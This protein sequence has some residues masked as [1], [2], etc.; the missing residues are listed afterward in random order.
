ML[1]EPQWRTRACPGS[2]GPSQMPCPRGLPPLTRSH[3]HLHVHVPLWPSS[4]TF[5]CSLA[6]VPLWASCDLSSFRFSR[7]GV[8]VGREGET[9][10]PGLGI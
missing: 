3:G 10:C 7:A 1:A 4:T 9:A 5:F 6:P 8:E 2:S